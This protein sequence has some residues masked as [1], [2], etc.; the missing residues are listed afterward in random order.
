MEKS[1]LTA[2][3]IRKKL[4]FTE[5]EKRAMF[6]HERQSQIDKNEIENSYNEKNTYLSF[7]VK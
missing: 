3:T 1:R 2:E 5:D 6:T 7:A 4:R